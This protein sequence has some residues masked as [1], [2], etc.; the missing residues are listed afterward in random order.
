MDAS[1]NR[2]VSGSPRRRIPP[3]AVRTGTLSWTLAAL[4]AFRPGS[5]VIPDDVTNPGGDRAGKNGVRDS[6]R[7]EAHP[8]NESKAESGREWNRAQEIP[9]RSR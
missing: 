5:A 9:G 1:R 7:V 6:R 3:A 2:R 4:A 8:W